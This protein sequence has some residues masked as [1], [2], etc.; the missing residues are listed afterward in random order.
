MLCRLAAIVHA[1][2]AGFSRTKE[3]AVP[4]AFAIMRV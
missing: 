1:D 2:F 4:Y 3:Q